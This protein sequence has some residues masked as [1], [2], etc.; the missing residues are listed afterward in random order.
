MQNRYNSSRKQF[1]FRQ[2]N[3]RRDGTWDAGDATPDN[4]KG[5]S[6]DLYDPVW[7]RWR[8]TPSYDD[9]GTSA[10]GTR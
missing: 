7:P 1:P 3:R 4:V 8:K 6:V 9:D 2:D 5:T 10:S